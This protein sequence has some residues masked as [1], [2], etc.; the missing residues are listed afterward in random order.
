MAST[1]QVAIPK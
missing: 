1:V